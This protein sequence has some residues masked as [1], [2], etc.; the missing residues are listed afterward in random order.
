MLH[1]P[2]GGLTSRR[3]TKFSQDITYVVLDGSFAH[4]ERCR[5][6]AVRLPRASWITTSRSR[7]VRPPKACLV[8]LRGDVCAG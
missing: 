8:A 2:N 6:L 5:D 7:A 1:C 3:E 4:H